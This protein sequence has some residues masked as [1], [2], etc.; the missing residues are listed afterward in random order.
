[1][2]ATNDVKK[3]EKKGG[4][5]K[6]RYQ[7]DPLKAREEE[8]CVESVSRQLVFIRQVEVMSSLSKRIQ[9]AKV[10]RLRHTSL[11][12]VPPRY[13]MTYQVGHCFIFDAASHTTRRSGLFDACLVGIGQNP[14]G[15][16]W[17]AEDP[18]VITT[19]VGEF[20][21]VRPVNTRAMQGVDEFVR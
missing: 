14:Y 11:A 7:K 5:V 9:Q 1:M 17:V 3:G 18:E 6:E 10:R 20:L 12:P 2:S 21:Q 16:I 4:G 19:D 15:V 8:V 13:R